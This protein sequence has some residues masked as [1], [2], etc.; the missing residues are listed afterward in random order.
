MILQYQE[1]PTPIH[2]LDSNANPSG[3]HE[4]RERAPSPDINIIKQQLNALK[5]DSNKDDQFHRIN[6]LE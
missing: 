5:S 4:I 2:D 1:P 3:Y 6:I